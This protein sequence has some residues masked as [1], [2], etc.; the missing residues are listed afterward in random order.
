M[1]LRIMTEIFRGDVWIRDGQIVK[2]G[3]QLAVAGRA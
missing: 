2:A 3:S 1:Y